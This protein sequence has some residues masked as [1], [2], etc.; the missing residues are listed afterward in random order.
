MSLRGTLTT[1]SIVLLVAFTLLA[2]GN[3]VQDQPQPDRTLNTSTP[4]RIASALQRVVDQMHHDG[5]TA[6][7]VTTRRP[8]A[9][10]TPLVR[11]DV[12]GRLHSVIMV[13][14]LD[15]AAL[16]TLA[17][18]HVHIEST[19]TVGHSVQSWVPFTQMHAVAQLP[20]V[21]FLHPPSY[22]RRR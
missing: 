6:E 7:N 10:S 19:D 13:T 2:C 20:F 3:V 17:I 18:H 9:Y 4:S 8:E 15:A 21:R 12:V 16:A 14:T 11:V 5:L 1:S 22:A